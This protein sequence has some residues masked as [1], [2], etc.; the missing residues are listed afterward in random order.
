[1]HHGCGRE[2][3]EME[4]L[5]SRTRLYTDSRAKLI[6]T[7]LDYEGD[8]VTEDS[9]PTFIALEF[10]HF[11]PLTL[12]RRSDGAQ[13]FTGKDHSPEEMTAGFF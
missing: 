1:M 10:L 4:G 5:T 3:Y 6:Q 12:W 7:Q 8:K 13:F 9:K 2:E 11:C